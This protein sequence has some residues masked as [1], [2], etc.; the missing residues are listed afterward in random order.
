MVVYLKQKQAPSEE[1][2]KNTEQIS[3]QHNNN[4]Q[5]Y[6]QICTRDTTTPM[7]FKIQNIRFFS[8]PADDT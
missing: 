5:T 7:G 2:K 3:E 1:E 4:T 8:L 6:V